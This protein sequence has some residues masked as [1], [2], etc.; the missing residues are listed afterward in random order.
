M[1][2][3]RGEISA[4]CLLCPLCPL[5]AIPF[6]QPSCQLFGC[7]FPLCVSLHPSASSALKPFCLP[8]LVALCRAASAT[9]SANQRSIIRV[10]PCPSVVSISVLFVFFCG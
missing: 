2:A 10:H 7:G 6:P 1:L 4:A 8:L 5:V 9:I 3:A